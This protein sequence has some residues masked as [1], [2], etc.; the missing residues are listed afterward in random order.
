MRNAR[1]LQ[2][3]TMRF[4]L[5]S[6][7]CRLPLLASCFCSMHKKKDA[8]NQKILGTEFVVG[9][10]VEEMRVSNTT[11]WSA[12]RRQENNQFTFF[13]L[14][15]YLRPATG[16]VGVADAGCKAFHIPC[17]L[18]VVGHSFLLGVPNHLF[19]TCQISYR[20]RWHLH[21]LHRQK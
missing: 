20:C 2:A 13:L 19:Q 12:A 17:H 11:Q 1:M 18:E 16:T 14:L 21:D 10:Y 6:F 4:G 5:A 8:G 7:V 3:K 15:D 9:F